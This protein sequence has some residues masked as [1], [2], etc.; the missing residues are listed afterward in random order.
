MRNNLYRVVC[1]TVSALL[2]PMASY[3]QNATKVHR[4]WEFGLGGS[5]TNITRTTVTNFRQTSGGDYVFT[6]DEKLLYGGVEAYSAME[7]KK[8]LYAD[9][10]ANIG[11][12]RY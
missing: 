3:S 8:W 10:Q 9:I 1:A 7:L 4:A 6:L 12:A 2:C 11:L 5:A